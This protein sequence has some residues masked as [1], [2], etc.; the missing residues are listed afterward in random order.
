MT[1]C[2]VPSQACEWRPG[3]DFASGAAGVEADHSDVG[4][5]RPHGRNPSL[6]LTRIASLGGELGRIVRTR[7]RRVLVRPSF[8]TLA[9]HDLVN[10]ADLEFIYPPDRYVN[11]ARVQ[12]LQ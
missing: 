11:V 9:A 4:G 2:S 6:P 7:T 12:L 3:Q 1:L 5:S 8:Y 10:H